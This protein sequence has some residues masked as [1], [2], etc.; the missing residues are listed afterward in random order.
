[1]FGP[2]LGVRHLGSSA[3]EHEG[4]NQGQGGAHG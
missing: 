4:N 1:L 2:P 3:A